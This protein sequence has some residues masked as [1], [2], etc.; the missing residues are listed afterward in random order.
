MEAHW[1]SWFRLLGGYESLGEGDV[2][3]VPSCTQ[4]WEEMSRKIL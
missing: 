4:E 3:E 1:L 2:H